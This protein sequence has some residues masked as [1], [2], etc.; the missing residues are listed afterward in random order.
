MSESTTTGQRPTDTMMTATTSSNAIASTP[1][2]AI[3]QEVP[4]AIQETKTDMETAPDD[5]ALSTP[6]QISTSEPTAKLA[7]AGSGQPHASTPSIATATPPATSSSP[8]S[9]QPQSTTLATDSSTDNQQIIRQS[10]PQQATDNS[11]ANQTPAAVTTGAIPPSTAATIPTATD[12]ID[13]SKPSDS[14]SLAAPVAAI[15]TL[16]STTPASDANAATTTISSTSVPLSS[17]STEPTTTAVEQAAA[18]T[19][20][21]TTVAPTSGGNH[22]VSTAPS[23]TA[24]PAP[25]TTASAV[26][27][28]T[29]TATLPAPTT[30]STTAVTTAAATS[31]TATTTP[32]TTTTPTASTTALLAT[33]PMKPHSTDVGDDAISEAASTQPGSPLAGKRPGRMTNQL[34]HLSKIVLPA[35]A[36]NPLS[37]PFR[38]PVDYKKLNIPTYPDVIKHPMDLGTIRKKLTKKEYY[39]SK[40]CIADVA[41]V[42][43]NCQTFNRPQDDVYKMS[44]TLQEEFERLLRSMPEP[45]EE[46][47][48]PA[49]TRTASN[50]ILT[51]PPARRQ[52]SR[53]V[54]APAR[55]MSSETL[56]GNRELRACLDIIKELLNKKHADYAWPFYEPVDVVKLNLHD[57]YDVIKEPM[58][59]STV[60]KNLDSG[61]YDTADAFARDVRLIFTNCYNYNPPGSDVV[62][63]ANSTSQVFEMLFASLKSGQN[64]AQVKTTSRRR[65]QSSSGSSSSD[66][67]DDAAARQMQQLQS[68][69]MGAYQQ[70]Q[71]IAGAGMAMP[72]NM[73]MLPAVV[74][75]K[76]KKKKKSKKSKRAHREKR[77]HDDYEEDDYYTERPAKT[78]KRSP[79]RYTQPA[80]T[81]REDS[82]AESDGGV[83]P[84]TWDEKRLL[85]QNIKLLPAHELHKI[86]DIVK[87]CE[88]SLRDTNSDEIE[89]DFDEL[90]PKTLREL[91]RFVKDSLPNEGTKVGP[92]QHKHMLES[93][94]QKALAETKSDIER[95]ERS[96]RKQQREEAKRKQEATPLLAPA[97]APVTKQAM[98][99]PKR[100][101][102]KS[103]QP[104]RA[105]AL[106]AARPAPADRQQS[107]EV[108]FDT[109]VPLQVDLP[110][111][112]DPS[113]SLIQ[114]EDMEPTTASPTKDGW[115]NDDDDDEEDGFADT[116]TSVSNLDKQFEQFQSQQQAA[117][118]RQRELAEA[119]E[120][121]QKEL[122]RQQEARAKALVEAE[123][124]RLAEKEQEEQRQAE[125]AA[126][127][128]EKERLEREALREQAAKERERMEAE[129]EQED[130][131]EDFDLE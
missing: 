37:W 103:K 110:V 63:M 89:I 34:A 82:D 126:A 107:T 18:T 78:A 15:T 122:A 60:R 10:A 45:E 55:S 118:A 5:A 16:A 106:A 73:G 108:T 129:A 26:P 6:T 36:K 86:V 104:K 46:I 105:P 19:A 23:S 42:W 71:A 11:T 128:A 127:Q 32:A 52:S 17:S 81:M 102:P 111:V 20:A 31:N 101:A 66:S 56:R 64:I 76:K 72:M 3:Q 83:L 14:T 87:A 75:K 109:E 13:T 84:M 88:P 79:T 25:H 47:K 28:T 57:Y 68:T 48:R 98:G 59:L 97:P 115:D 58:D 9:E 49:P 30:S 38:K 53:T 35:L 85:S 43:R 61:K 114:E 96:L 12:T 27:T 123:Q 54:K 95:Q 39:S 29:A 24:A 21:T 1:P 100:Q 80:M 121:R 116:P 90:Q 65:V 4:S 91:D 2:T 41:L 112:A 70:L 124:Q 44:Q 51:G 130:D 74:P 119:E 8:A 69:I 33:N 40:E 93:Q 62:K 22:A 131:D 7:E 67:E 94:K 120:R 125:E 92:Q 99:P 77:V 50:P 117:E 113:L